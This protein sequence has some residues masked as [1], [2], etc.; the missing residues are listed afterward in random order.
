MRRLSVLFLASGM[1][2]PTFAWSQPTSVT[3]LLDA[4]DNCIAISAKRFAVLSAEPA[5]IVASGA[6][7]MCEQEEKAYR[8]A[9]L[10]VLGSDKASDASSLVADF[11]RQRRDRLIAI[12]LLNRAGVVK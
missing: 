3:P 7:G 6:F 12:I 9:A 2:A 11:K 1:L 8:T 10:R 4:W 5:D